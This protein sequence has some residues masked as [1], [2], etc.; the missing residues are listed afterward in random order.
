M[1]CPALLASIP[2]CSKLPTSENRYVKPLPMATSISPSFGILPPSFLLSKP[3]KDIT[4]SYIDFANSA[5]P[6]YKGRYAVILDNV[7]SSSECRALVQATEAGTSGVWEP[8]MVNIGGGRQK[9]SLG[10][11]NCGRIIWDDAEL[12]G[13]ILGRVRSLLPELEELDNQPNVTGLKHAIEGTAFRLTRPN[14]RMRFLRY[15][16]GNYFRRS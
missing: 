13:R 16:T 7:L 6:S 12:A 4:K 10:V 15:E 1:A 11:R 3:E 8:A 2:R 5:I 9:L 14:E